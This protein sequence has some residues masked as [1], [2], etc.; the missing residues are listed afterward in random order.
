MH[1]TSFT[2]TV[3]IEKHRN[4]ILGFLF[5]SPSLSKIE[6]SVSSM[7]PMGYVYF[8]VV[9]ILAEILAVP[10]VPLT[11]SSGYLFGIWKGSA[12]VLFSASIAAAT[13][14]MIG[15]TLLRSTVEQ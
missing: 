8:S 9:Y 12:V 11:A 5:F 14:F 4:I 2:F 15:R 10:A 6:N 13:S 1:I 3:E 7:G